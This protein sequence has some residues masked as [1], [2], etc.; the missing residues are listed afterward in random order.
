ME[1][2]EK[3]F[4]IFYGSLAFQRMYFVY[5]ENEL[6]EYKDIAGTIM[7]EADKYGRV[8]YG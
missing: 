5:T 2:R 7:Y 8:I 3:K 6:S 1:H 4:L